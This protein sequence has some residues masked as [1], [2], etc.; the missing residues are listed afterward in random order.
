M[1]RFVIDG[2]FVQVKQ[3]RIPARPYVRPAFHAVKGKIPS[4]FAGE[5][6]RIMRAK[7]Y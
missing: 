5:A 2:K 4:V 1:L 3:V 6:A 7:G